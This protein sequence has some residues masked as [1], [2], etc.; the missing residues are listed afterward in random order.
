MRRYTS[1][2][3]FLLLMLL[4]NVSLAQSVIPS[5]TPPAQISDPEKVCPIVSVSC[6]S[7]PDFRQPV[8][9]SASI[10]GGDPNA[11]PT[12]HWEVSTGVI[13]EGQGT[14]TIKVS[15]VTLETVTATLRVGGLDAIC[16]KTA[17]CSTA[18]HLPVPPAQKFDSYEFVSSEIETAKLSLFADQLLQQPGAQ[19]YVLFYGGRPGGADAARAA[20]KRAKAHLVK[21]RGIAADRIV[22]VEGGQKERLTID[23][24]IVPT[25]AIPPKP[26]PA[27]N[28]GV[29]PIKS[30]VQKQQGPGR[31]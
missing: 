2:L 20:G 25:G 15:V 29:E 18:I 4:A 14:S 3:S 5:P 6:P 26:E 22:I 24:W 8:E 16:S 23:L 28:P 31:H 27:I 13:T 12:Y 7:N 21:E 9:F 30:L 1:L 17:S 11:K 19:G 10:S